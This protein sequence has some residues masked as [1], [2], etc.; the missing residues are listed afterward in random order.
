MQTERLEAPGEPQEE[1]VLVF[2]STNYCAHDAAKVTLW[3]E[4]FVCIG[5][6]RSQGP[7]LHMNKQNITNITMTMKPT[8]MVQG[9]YTLHYAA[10][11]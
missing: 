10:N 11:I 2:V 4:L 5:T 1:K 8:G 3:D 9:V 6:P 7:V